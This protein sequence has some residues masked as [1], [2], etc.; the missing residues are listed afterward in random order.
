[1]LREGRNNTAP[2]ILFE[3]MIFGRADNNFRH[4]QNRHR[5]IAV[6]KEALG[7]AQYEEERILKLIPQ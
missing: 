1:L 7:D 2:L 4:V 6:E 5:W 3:K